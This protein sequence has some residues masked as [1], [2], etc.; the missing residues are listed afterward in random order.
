MYLSIMTET[1]EQ[2]VNPDQR[3]QNTESDQ[4]TLFAS[5]LDWLQSPVTKYSSHNPV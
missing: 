3:P 1:L 2:T 4:S 5:H